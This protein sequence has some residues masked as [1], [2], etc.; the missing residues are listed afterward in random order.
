MIAKIIGATGFIGRNLAN[1]LEQNYHIE[2]VSLRDENWRENLANT[3]AF[4]NLV[5]KAHDHHKK[6]TKE[7]FYYINVDLAKNIFDAFIKSDAHLFIHISSL[8]ALEEFES[9]KALT[10]EDRC[11]PSSWYGKSKREAEVWL[12]KQELPENKKLIILR[13]PMV[14]GSGDKGN[15]GLLYKLISKG[16]PYPLSSFKNKR[17]FIS[18]DNFCFFID[19]IIKNEEKLV[20]GIYHISDDEAVSTSQ[21]INIIKEVENKRTINLSLPKFLV[22]SLA[23]VGDIIPIPLNS[24]R[25]RKMTSDLTVS[26][27]K[28]KSALGIEK[29]P[30]S[31]EE[32]LIKTIKSFKEKK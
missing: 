15:L 25:L 14:H 17:S 24:L 12:L 10:E 9:S 8:A 3:G 19:T 21:I 7:D 16:I 32:G 5:G 30:L 18:I 28:I 31:A 2:K 1:Y 20:S 27:Q 22:R 26:N 23:K 29:L 13:P 6:G 4:V 11:N